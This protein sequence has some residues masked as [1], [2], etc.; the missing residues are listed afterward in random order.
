M[1]M[2]NA[3]VRALTNYVQGLYKSTLD[4][5]QCGATRA[6]FDPFMYLSV[7]LPESRM[8]SLTLHM[9]YMDGSQHPIK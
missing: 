7:P 5:P 8:L 9:V 4:C 3:H 6:K 1:R 2:C